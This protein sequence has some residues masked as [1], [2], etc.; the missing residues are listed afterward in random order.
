MSAEAKTV[1]E[2][3]REATAGISAKDPGRVPELGQRVTPER[4]YAMNGRWTCHQVVVMGGTPSEALLEP[5]YWKDVAHLIK[6]SDRIWIDVDD[7]SFTGLLVVQNSMP[8]LG[9]VVGWLAFGATEVRLGVRDAGLE[10]RVGAT[11]EYR[12]LHSRW[13]AMLNGRILRDGL[14]TKGQASQWLGGH[15]KTREA[16]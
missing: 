1:E 12:G 15:L 6:T 4:V 7:G 10:N 3:M 8:G 5:G 13:A 14:A 9:L 2:K 16:T 11:V